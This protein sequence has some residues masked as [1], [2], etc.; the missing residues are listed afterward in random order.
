MPEMPALAAAFEYSNSSV[1]FISIDS[2]KVTFVRFFWLC[3]IINLGASVAQFL[4]CAIAVG[5]M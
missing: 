1:P 4:V 2:L 3:Q 5:Y